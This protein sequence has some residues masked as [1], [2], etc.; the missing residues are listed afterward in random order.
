MEGYTKSKTHMAANFNNLPPIQEYTIPYNVKNLNNEK[1]HQGGYVNYFSSQH[2]T[3]KAPHW[4]FPCFDGKQIS[5]N[6]KNFN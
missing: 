3:V 5:V 4:Y 6:I 2:P 1:V